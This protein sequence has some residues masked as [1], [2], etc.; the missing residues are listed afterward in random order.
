MVV[1]NVVQ[2]P[3]I[4]NVGNQ[5]GLIIV[6]RI[7]NQNGKVRPQRRDV[8]Y[9]QTRLL[10]AQKEKVGIQLQDEEFDLMVAAGDLDEIEEVNANCILMANLQHASTSGTQT[11]NVPVYD[12]DGSTE[13]DSN[14]ISAA[15]SLKQNKET[16]EQNSAPNK[17]TRA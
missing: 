10:I 9:L 6:S 3:G 14:V 11:D 7:A 16:T 12:S 8:A 15:P 5:N 17:E 1:W 4:Q 2:N 13:N